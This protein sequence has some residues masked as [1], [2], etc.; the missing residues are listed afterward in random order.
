MTFW[1]DSA[2]SL[3]SIFEKFLWQGR[4]NLSLASACNGHVE[5]MCFTVMGILQNSQVG[6]NWLVS[7]VLSVCGCTLFH[8]GA[9]QKLGI[10]VHQCLGL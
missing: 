8:R 5:K 7:C 10:C 1:A 3:L 2:D 9:W 6:E 4:K